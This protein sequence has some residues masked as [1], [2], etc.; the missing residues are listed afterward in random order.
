MTDGTSNPLDLEEW[1]RRGGTDDADRD[2][3]IR[4]GRGRSTAALVGLLV[5]VSSALWAVTNAHRRSTLD[6]PGPIVTT[7]KP[8][9]ESRL[10][11]ATPDESQPPK[12]VPLLSD[13]PKTVSSKTETDARA[14]R[15]LASSPNPFDKLSLRNPDPF[16]LDEHTASKIEEWR[17]LV[18]DESG[19]PVVARV[20]NGPEGKPFA[21]MPDGRLGI[22]ERIVKT[23]SPF[24]LA[25]AEEMEKVLLSG[26]CKGFRVVRAKH[27]LVFYNGTEK[28]AL[29]SARLLE[30]LYQGLLKSF[31]NHRLV[32]HEA[33]FPLAAIIYRDERE[34]RER[35]E[36]APEIQA[37]YE[38]LTNR[39][40][41]FENSERD[42][43]SPEVA[44]LRKPQTV[45]HEGVHQILQNIGVQPRLAPWPIWLIEGL[46]EYCATTSPARGLWEKMG[47]VNPF[48]MAT[49][50][51]LQTSA[52]KPAANFRRGGRPPRQ[53]IVEDLIVK[54]E[55]TPTDYARS[56][57]LTH[58]LAVRHGKEFAAYLRDLGK[59][60]P[61][62]VRTPKDHL[63][64]FQRVFNI[65]PAALDKKIAK[66]LNDLKYDKIPY[67]VV[68]FERV[69]PNGFLSRT[70]L[71]SQ[72][73]SVIREWIDETINQAPGVATWHIV[74]FPN[75][76]DAA[77]LM[78][79]WVEGL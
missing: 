58:Y 73:P 53:S 67:Y 54:T 51:D 65:A 55:L 32:V 75:R 66:Y 9:A 71:V 79:G 63:A 25:T 5:F 20:L 74:P 38:I 11:S 40:Y 56:W 36:I 30:S 47:I 37:Y 7:N 39:V 14:A 8:T 27:Y 50:T 78:R 18:A 12:S 24:V 59:L 52:L 19:R 42:R 60:S 1:A 17:S 28:F 22:L 49:I 3:R 46:A 21:L 29:D 64:E 41:F 62:D 72:S 43:E 26:V 35:R 23:D 16:P 44:A 45:A 34:F 61:S 33:E 6:L 31:E 70:G 77:L 76:E 2:A 10:S 69:A 57:A 48:H 4:V 15:K 13:S 68:T